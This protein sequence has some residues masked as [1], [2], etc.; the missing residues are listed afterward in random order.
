MQRIRNIDILITETLNIKD[1][2]RPRNSLKE[3]YKKDQKSYQQGFLN[4][5]WVYCKEKYERYDS[6]SLDRRKRTYFEKLHSQWWIYFCPY[7]GKNG[8]VHFSVVGRNPYEFTRLYDIEHFL[9]RR[10]YSA[11][12][13]NLYNRLPACMSCNQRLK[14]DIDPLKDSSEAERIFHPYFWWIYKAETKNI[15]KLIEI[16][17]KDFDS[18]MTFIK[19]EQKNE[20]SEF[21]LTS[22]HGKT[23]QLDSI[24]LHSDD[25]FQIFRFIYD[26]YT[27]IKDNLCFKITWEPIG[28]LVEHFFSSYYPKN[29]QDILKYSNGKY[30]KDLIQYMVKLLE[31]WNKNLPPAQS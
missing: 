14:K 20:E 27:K 26:K 10:K 9:P 12:S 8:I 19:S 2:S 22:H 13:I 18:K 11:L 6:Q 17:D 5:Q 28:V 25:T 7:C 24:Y 31:S 16:G 15:E 29:E 30:K 21:I 4:H 3:E 23:F 1:S